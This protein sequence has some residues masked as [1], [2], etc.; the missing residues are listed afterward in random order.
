MR[1][2]AR[3]MGARGNLRTLKLICLSRLLFPMTSPHA[4]PFLSCPGLNPCLHILPLSLLSHVALHPHAVRRVRR[5]W[6][7]RASSTLRRRSTTRQSNACSRLTRSGKRSWVPTTSRLANSS[8]PWAPFAR[9]K[10]VLCPRLACVAC[11]RAPGDRN[12]GLEMECDRRPMYVIRDLG[13]RPMY[14]R[15]DLGET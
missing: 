13:R 10:C 6:W 4:F 5:C 12:D 15:R 9:S 7:P 2:C 1:A 14:V 3:H 8:A 11:L